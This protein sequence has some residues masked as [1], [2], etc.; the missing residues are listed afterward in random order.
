MKHFRVTLIL[1][2]HT[3]RRVVAYLLFDD[4]PPRGLS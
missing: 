2:D 1:F 3:F 4:L